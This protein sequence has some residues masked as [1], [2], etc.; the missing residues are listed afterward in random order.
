M[1]PGN[2]LSSANT[3]RASLSALRNVAG[4]TQGIGLGLGGL[5]LGVQQGVTLLKTCFNCVS[6]G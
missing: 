4:L 6:F 3:Q 1:H 2:L 5:L